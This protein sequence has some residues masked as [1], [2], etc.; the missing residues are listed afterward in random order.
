VRPAAEGGYG[1]DAQWS[2]DYHHAVHALVTGERDGYYEG[3]GRVADVAKALERVFVYDGQYD[4][5]RDRRHGR[6]VGDLPRHRFLAYLQNHDQTGNRARGDR[7]AALVADGH[8][9]AAAALTLLSPFVPLLFQGE[10]WGSRVPFQYFTDH[11][12]EALGHA[13]TEGRRREF[14]SF[15]W[16]PEDVP[17]P[18]DPATF[19]RSRLDWD[20]RARPG[21]AAILEWHRALVALRARLPRDARPVVA[22][23]EDGRWLVMGRGAWTVVCNFSDRRQSV[24]AGA[25]AGREVVLASTEADRDGERVTLGPGAVVLG[26]M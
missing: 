26:P 25:A 8:L 5:H 1:L 9:R 16:K 4:P 21:H 12:D 23:D 2:D 18:Q 19:E 10:E 24:P 11:E 3:F 13:V 7:L 15:G 17:D 22:A 20:E 14:A 6:P